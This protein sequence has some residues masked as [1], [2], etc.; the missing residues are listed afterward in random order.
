MCVHYKGHWK[1]W[2]LKIE[3]F[4]NLEMAMSAAKQTPSNGSCNG[5][6]R[7]KILKSKRHKKRHNKKFGNNLP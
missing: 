3:T 6:A 4:L 1:G 7:I 2:D 5:F